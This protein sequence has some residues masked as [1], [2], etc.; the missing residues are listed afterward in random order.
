MTSSYNDLYCNL[1]SEFLRFKWFD[2]CHLFQDWKID[3]RK[4]LSLQLL[5]IKLLFLQE[6]IVLTSWMAFSKPEHLHLKVFIL[7]LKLIFRTWETISKL[8]LPDVMFS[9]VWKWYLKS[10]LK[11][12]E[13]HDA[14]SLGVCFH[15]SFLKLFL[16]ELLLEWFLWALLLLWLFS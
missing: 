12:F 9:Q 16:S 7:S 5:L 3:L 13:L 15:L 6:L 1:D 11:G 14:V 4:N 8:N 2:D 10:P